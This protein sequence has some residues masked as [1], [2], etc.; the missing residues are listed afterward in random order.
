MKI[1]YIDAHCHLHGKEYDTDREEVLAR[2]R[3]ANVCAI[4][5]GTDIEESRA[6]VALAER[7]PD[8]WATV[9]QHPT[10][11]HAEDFDA[12]KYRELAKSSKVVAIGECGL[13]YF[14][15]KPEDEAEKNRQRELFK[16][17]LALALELDKPLMIHCRPSKGTED[18]HEEMIQILSSNSRELEDSQKSKLRGA[19]HFFTGSAEV[20]KKY[21]E[22]GFAVSFPGVITFAPELEDCVRAVSKDFILSETDSPYASPVPYRGKRNEPVRV[23]EVV[24]KISSIRGEEENSM[25]LSIM[26][27]AKRVFN[28]P[29]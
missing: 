21:A 24:K 15:I 1:K 20:A 27:N 4:T 23:L 11:N 18:A 16:K 6:A 7:H 10:D 9:G 19:I 8:I 17:Q 12:D 26:S 14:R 22:I 3:E 25:A 13:D 5:V 28:L 29:I 2:M